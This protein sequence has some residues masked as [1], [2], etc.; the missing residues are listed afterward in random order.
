[1]GPSTLTISTPGRICLFGEHQ[2]YLGLAVIAAAISRRISIHGTVRADNRMILKL[3]DI[4]SEVSFSVGGSLPYTEERDYFRSCVNVLQKHGHHF[5]RGYDCMVRGNI[6]INAGT[7]SSS[8]LVV[9]WIHFL[10]HVS[11]YPVALSQEDIGKLAH[12]AEVLEF[13]EPGG[14]MDHYSTALGGLVFLESHP[15]IKIASLEARLGTFVLGNSIENKNTKGILARVKSEVSEA[16]VAAKKIYPEFSF[17]SFK[18][19][20]LGDFRKPLDKRHYDLL[21]AT[22]VNRDLTLEA[23][24]LLQSKNIDHHKLGSLLNDHQKSLRDVLGISTPKIDSMLEAALKAGA[25]GGKINGSGGGGC[26]FAYAPDNA[27]PVAEAIKTIGEATILTVD[28]GTHR[29]PREN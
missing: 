9:S 16:A 23:R 19:D 10:S 17:H 12:E 29:E 15:Q 20:Q 3:P 8:A 24:G 18:L 5:S 27:E 4:G 26:M 1:M 28:T 22:I 14:M 2:D 7:S 6:P 21:K 25:L 13:S 11:D